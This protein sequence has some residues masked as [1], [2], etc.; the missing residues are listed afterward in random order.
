MPSYKFEYFDGRGRGELTRYVFHAAGKDFDDSRYTFEQWASVK[1]SAPFG[2]LPILHVDG[3]RL[4]QS[5]AI[6]RFLAREFGLAGKNSWEQGLVDQYMELAV[7]MFKEV[8]KW[9]FEKDE[10]KKRECLKNLREV[11]YPKYCG[12]FQNALEQNGGKY[13]V[14]NDLTLADLAVLD[15]FDTPMHHT[16]NIMDSFPKL[17]AHRERIASTANLASY[18]KKRKVTDI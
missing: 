12:L 13:F 11:V 2:Q 14:G 3:K 16:S 8:I 5:G 15:I 6:A 10:E 4:A 1:P 7:D 17:K 18:I 9:Y